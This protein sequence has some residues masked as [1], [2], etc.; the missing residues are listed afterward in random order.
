MCGVGNLQVGHNI[1]NGMWIQPLNSFEFGTELGTL[2]MGGLGRPPESTVDDKV[3]V[4]NS[5]PS[6]T[7]LGFTATLMST[8]CY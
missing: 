6:R 1:Q 7:Y 8:T 4:P 2:T 5:A 3:E